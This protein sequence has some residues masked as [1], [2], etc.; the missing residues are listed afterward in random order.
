VVAAEAA[1]WRSEG[2]THLAVSTMTS[3]MLGATSRPCAGV[4]DHL[5][6]LAEVRDTIA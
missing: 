5:A 6:L 4:D 2:G 1:D 3:A